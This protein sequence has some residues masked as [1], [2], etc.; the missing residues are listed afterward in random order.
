MCFFLSFRYP[1][2][3]LTRLPQTTFEVIEASAPPAHPD[4]KRLSSSEGSV[5]SSSPS[6][7]AFSYRTIGPA[8]VLRTYQAK[9]SSGGSISTAGTTPEQSPKEFDKLVLPPF[10]FCSDSLYPEASLV[11]PSAM[12]LT[13]GNPTMPLLDIDQRL[14]ESHTEQP[15]ASGNQFYKVLRSPP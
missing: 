5:S 12:D 11:D 9:D 3:W 1:K 15:Y 14:P 13:G 6:H 4:T 2:C 8:I 10:F 7:D